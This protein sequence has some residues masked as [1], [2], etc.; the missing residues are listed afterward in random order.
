[1]FGQR[2]Q[3]Y[4]TLGKLANIAFDWGNR[5]T[6]EGTIKS[7]TSGDRMGSTEV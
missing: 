4:A 7:L 1:M 3:T 6:A 5:Q 2:F